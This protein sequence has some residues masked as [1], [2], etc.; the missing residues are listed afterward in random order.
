MEHKDL[1]FMAEKR[2]AFVD[3]DGSLRRGYHVR[4]FLK[5]HFERDEKIEQEYQLVE[6]LCFQYENGLLEYQKFVSDV[7]N[8]YSSYLTGRK[9]SDVNRIAIE[10]SRLD[11]QMLP[12]FEVISLLNLLNIDVYIVTGSPSHI[13][14]PYLKSNIRLFGTEFQQD[15]G[16]YKKSITAYFGGAD[17]KRFIASNLLSENGLKKAAFAVGDSE[18]DTPLFDQ[19]YFYIRIKEN[20]VEFISD[21]EKPFCIEMSKFHDDGIAHVRRILSL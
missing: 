21:Q 11:S 8:V 19:S 7:N 4:D 1:R 5:F 18:S 12:T 2:L 16:V 15:G 17:Q 10:F 3:W 14:K 6:K 20:T 13:V 9:L